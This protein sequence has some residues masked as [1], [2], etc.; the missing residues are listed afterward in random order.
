MLGYYLKKN[1]IARVVYCSYKTC[2]WHVQISQKNH[3]FIF[4][5]MFRDDE[6]SSNPPSEYLKIGRYLF[7]W[8]TVQSYNWRFNRG[9][10]PVGVS[11]DFKL[12]WVCEGWLNFA[13]NKSRSNMPLKKTLCRSIAVDVQTCA[14]C[15]CMH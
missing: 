13:I 12:Y 1:G 3:E 4:G 8:A 14:T 15:L 9:D 11:I 5:S 7:D 6:A 2:L 10:L